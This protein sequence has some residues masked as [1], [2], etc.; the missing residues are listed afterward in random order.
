MQ[1]AK[2]RIAVA[3][4]AY[5]GNGGIASEV[6]DIR[7]WSMKFALAANSDP[8]VENVVFET[9][10]DTPITMTRNRAIEW[11][12]E[13]K[14]DFLIMLDSDQFPDMYVGDDPSAK[15]FFES[16][17]DFLCDHYKKGPATVFAPYCGPPPHPLF[18]GF[19]NVYVFRWLKNASCFQEPG[20]GWMFES[21]S[22]AEAA[23]LGG[24]QNADA[25][26]TGVCMIDMR[27]FD[28]LVHP[29]FD[30]EWNGEK[31]SCPQCHQMIPGPRTEKGSTEDIYFFRNI[32]LHGCLRLGYNPVYCNW[33]SWAGHWKPWCVGKPVGLSSDQV[34]R[35]FHEIVKANQR[36]D[37]KTV[38]L[39]KDE[40]AAPATNGVVEIS[41]EA[42]LRDLERRR[43]EAGDG[44]SHVPGSDPFSTAQNTDAQDLEWLCKM[45]RSEAASNF[46]TGGKFR[47][48]EIGSW[49]GGSAIAMAKTLSDMADYEIHCVDHWK[50]GNLIQRGVSPNGEAY[51]QFRLNTAPLGDRIIAH[52]GSSEEMAKEWAK[53]EGPARTIDFLFIDA[54]HTYEGC[55]TDI[56][57]WLPFLRNGAIICGHDYSSVAP[58]VKRAVHDF[59]SFEEVQV[60][61]T[62]W[63]A[64]KH[65]T[66]ENKMVPLKP[67]PRFK[68]SRKIYGTKLYPAELNGTNGCQHEKT[69]TVPGPKKK[70]KTKASSTTRFSK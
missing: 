6:P 4:F 29:Y 12:K 18:G 21:Y 25:G 1:P 58:G 60:I 35:H 41:E 24:I 48:V 40:N 20:R 66:P 36:A 16:T 23:Q 5:G 32:A 69:S 54:D 70:R 64:R 17:F 13:V 45:V 26:P 28:H 56:Q 31:H 62:V 19:E 65:G 39:R 51:D 43:K 50:G 67:M 57:C 22:R 30:Y 47:V 42:M 34:S 52:R 37:V 11:A 38:M 53:R 3:N 59:F 14:A 46:V 61:G 44:P 2:Y 7:K 55:R 68:V 63:A 8:R 49:T 15:P 9:F 10:S 27:I 33:D